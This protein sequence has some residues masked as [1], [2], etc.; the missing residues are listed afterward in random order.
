MSQSKMTKC[1]GHYCCWRSKLDCSYPR[2]GTICDGPQWQ[3][4][5]SRKRLRSELQKE[6]LTFE[7]PVRLTHKGFMNVNSLWRTVGGDE[8]KLTFEAIVFQ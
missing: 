1:H 2:L 4:R 8:G 3:A 5:S 7:L 6:V